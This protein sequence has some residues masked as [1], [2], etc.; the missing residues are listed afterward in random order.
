MQKSA[1][2]GSQGTSVTSAVGVSDGTAVS[3]GE[4]GVL[5]GGASVLMT[6]GVFVAS[7]VVQDTRSR[8]RRKLDICF[9]R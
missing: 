5:V 6:T 4:S 7:T 2:K 3:V 1:R 8:N 9:I